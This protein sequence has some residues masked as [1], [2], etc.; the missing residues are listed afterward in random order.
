MSRHALSSPSRASLAGDSNSVNPMGKGI[1]AAL[2]ILA[3]TARLDAQDVDAVTAARVLEQAFVDC[4]AD[5]ERS[6]VAIARIETQQSTVPP[7]RVLDPFAIPG[8]QPENPRSREFVPDHFGSGMIVADPQNSEE[9]YVLTTF[10]VAYGENTGGQDAIDRD[11]NPL[12]FIRLASGEVIEAT[13]EP[14]A[15]DWRSD[16]AVLRLDLQAAGVDP[17]DVIPIELGSAEAIRKGRLVVVLGN[18]YAQARDGSA[19]ASIGMISNTAR[20]PLPPDDPKGL[21]SDDAS[22]HHFGTLLQ[23]DSRLNLGASGGLVVDLEGRAIGLTTSLAALRGYESSVGY[24]I[25]FDEQIRKLIDDLIAGFEPEYGFL[26][27]HPRTVTRNQVTG[28]RAEFPQPSA[29]RVIELALGSP[30]DTAGLERGDIVLRIN[31]R[32]VADGVDLMRQIGLLG[33]DAQVELTVWREREAA[34]LTLTARLG[35]WPVY[36]DSRIISTATRFPEWR[37]LHV[38]Y[39][40]AR[41]RFMPSDPLSVYRRAVVVTAVAEGS[42]AAAA[43]LKPGDFIE[44]VEDTHVERPAEFHAAATGRTGQ[45]T[46]TMLDGSRRTIAP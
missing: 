12:V 3:A 28:N 24:A 40:T 33:P 16:L 11:T 29:V 4:I 8:D 6:V 27:I 14:R 1:A 23:I 42:P 46:L 21:M 31:N 25:P 30:A 44:K 26:G 22:I 2:I 18:P 43:G 45:V 20:R 15:A 36:N 5:A 32:T 17:A 38:D 19:S 34:T 41:K 37:G 7:L 39:P 13:T 9:R 10:R 35:K